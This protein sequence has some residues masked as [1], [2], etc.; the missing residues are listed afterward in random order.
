MIGDS[1][2]HKIARICVLPLINTSISPNHITVI[3]LITGLLAC[4]AFASKLNILGGIFWLISTFLDRADGELARISGK[5]TEWGHKFDYYCDTFITALFFI[6]IGINLRDNLSG[7]WSISL[8]IC[9]A[10]GVIFTEVYAEIID[11]KKQSTGEKAYPG[12]MGFDFDDILYLFA[13]IVWLNWHL[14]FLIGASIGA[15]AFAIFTWYSSK[16]I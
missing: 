6:A 8:G 16:K 4:A 14:P 7:Y 15:P 5:S 12:I 9:A 13:P 1:W 11:Q 3:R 10:L 2:T